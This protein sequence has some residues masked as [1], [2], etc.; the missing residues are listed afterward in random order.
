MTIQDQSVRRAQQ[1]LTDCHARNTAE[2]HARRFTPWL[3][4]ML[5]VAIAVLI[6][7]VS[8]S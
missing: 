2:R 3:L 5:A 7:T 4:L 8:R 6:L 1:Y